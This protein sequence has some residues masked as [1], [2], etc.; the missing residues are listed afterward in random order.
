LAV[1]CLFSSSHPGHVLFVVLLR[2]CV[3]LHVE[4]LELCKGLPGLEELGVLVGS[5]LQLY[6][7]YITHVSQRIVS[8]EGR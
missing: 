7:A 4:V 1:A 6:R 8:F 2:L 5:G 3:L